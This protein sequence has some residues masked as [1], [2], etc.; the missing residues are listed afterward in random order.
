[1]AAS[2][3]LELLLRARD[4]ASAALAGV[5]ERLGGL[6]NVS[7]LVRT[8]LGA[9]AGLGVGEAFQALAQDVLQTSELMARFGAVTGASAADV[10]AMTGVLNDLFRSNTQGREAIA[11]VMEGLATLQGVSTSNAVQMRQLAQAYLDFSKVTGVDAAQA[12]ALFDDVLDAWGLT[13][14]DATGIMDAL[15]ESHRRFGTDVQGALDVLNRMAPSFSALGLSVNDALGYINLFATAGVNAEGTAR[16]F[17]QAL[18]VLTDT[19]E[20]G[21]Q[22]LAQLGMQIGL[23]G[24]ALQQFLALSPA[25]KFQVLTQALM[26]MEDPAMRAQL[27]IDLFG[28]RAGPALANALAQSGG[29]LAQFQVDL[30]S[31]QGA[32]AQAAD[33]IDSTIT[34]KLRI[35]GHEILGRASELTQQL[36]P[37]FQIVAALAGPLAPVIGSVTGALSGLASAIAGPLMSSIMGLLPVLGPAGLIAVGLIGAGVAAFIFRDQIM[38]AFDFVRDHIVRI[39]GEVKDF[40]ARNWQEIVS[41]ASLI[42]LGPAGLVVLFTTNAFGIRDKVR[43]AFEQLKAQL[44]GIWNGAKEALE[45]IWNGLKEAG[46][47]T[48]GALRD[49][50]SGI[51]DSA[52]DLVVG[53]FEAMKDSVVGAVSALRDLAAGIMGNARDLVAGAADAARDLV[54]GAFNRMKDG[55]GMA[56]WGLLETVR[57]IPGQI[58]DALGDLGSLLW[59]AGRALIRGLIDGIKSMAGE[60][61]GVLGDLK[62]KITSWKGPLTDDVRLL[63]P[64]GRAIMEGLMAGI[65]SGL[66]DLKGLMGDVTGLVAGMPA[67]TAAPTPAVVGGGIVVNVAVHGPVYGELGFEERITAIVRDALRRGAFHGLLGR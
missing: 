43:E 62:D 16:A 14:E 46:E 18:N 9:L 37:A 45:G 38:Q 58:L 33:Q 66:P 20:T 5:Q 65:E 31:V 34:A 26:S 13:A 11:A 2:A 57:G 15:V 1:M 32:T 52:R 67:P 4:E 3:T 50:L 63:V 19:S 29:S 30:Q 24:D 40:L 8:A 25:E 59:G 41:I 10:R 27:A 22:K 64:H 6:G 7:G 53:A 54:V 51:A 39:W 17:N 48:F 36:G 44:E 21:Q 28:T 12:V 42:L 60:L 55:V 49:A 47:A 35:L 61:K 23:S 56:L